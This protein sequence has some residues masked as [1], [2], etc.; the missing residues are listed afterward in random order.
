MTRQ[1]FRQHE[2][3]AIFWETFWTL[4]SAVSVFLMFFLL[5][6]RLR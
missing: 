4:V 5:H 3:H 1:E 6:L 2:R